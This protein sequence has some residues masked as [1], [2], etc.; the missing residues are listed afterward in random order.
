MVRC[1]PGGFAVYLAGPT[2]HSHRDWFEA[3]TAHPHGRN[4]EIEASFRFAS[5][6]QSGALSL[7][8]RGWMDEWHPVGQPVLLSRHR[9]GEERE[10]SVQGCDFCSH[11][12]V[13]YRV[14]KS[15][16]H[17]S[18]T[19]P[20]P[21]P[22]PPLPPPQQWHLPRMRSARTGLDWLGGRLTLTLLIEKKE[23][24][25]GPAKRNKPTKRNHE[26]GQRDGS[27]R[28]IDRHPP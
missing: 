7:P 15:T 19:P 9:R 21:S 2:F 11:G 24:P 4:T 27:H 16:A 10:A 23:T 1:V 8:R 26:R 14:P 5:R 28:I 17:T 13:N 25:H 12:I 20:P 18:H 22:P 3:R 6:S